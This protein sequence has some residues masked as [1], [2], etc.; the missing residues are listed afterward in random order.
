MIG[1]YA[2]WV[3]PR[4]STGNYNTFKEVCKINKIM[5]DLVDEGYYNRQHFRVRMMGTIYYSELEPTKYTLSYRYTGVIPSTI[6]NP[7]SSR[8][9]AENTNVSLTIP[10]YLGY[11]FSGWN[12]STF[13]NNVTT[14]KMPSSNIEFTG[15]WT[16]NTDT[17]Y[18]VRL[19]REKR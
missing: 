17:K 14:I 19:W 12:N 11:T 15:S 10:N 18:E 7:P 2:T 16:A 9:V 4:G 1:K 5:V 3:Y 6:G 13:G 8:Q